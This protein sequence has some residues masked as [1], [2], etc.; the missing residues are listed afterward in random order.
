MKRYG[1]LDE[2]A[3]VP[4][5]RTGQDLLGNHP[6][7]WTDQTP[8]SSAGLTLSNYHDGIGTLY[9]GTSEQYYYK[10]ALPLLMPSL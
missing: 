10:V 5:T 7:R 2:A 8:V 3:G 1:S 6:A 4:P 9:V